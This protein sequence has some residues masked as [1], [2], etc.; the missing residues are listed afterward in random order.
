MIPVYVISLPN[1]ERREKIHAELARVGFK[2]VEY[3]SAK[4]PVAD[5]TANNFRRNPR[6]EYGCALSHIKA[7]TAAISDGCKEALFIEDDV[8]FADN[9]WQQLGNALDLLERDYDV[10]YLG[11]HP[12]GPVEKL[13]WINLY[14][15]TGG[16]SCAEAYCMTEYAMSGF[17][18]YWCDRAGQKNAMIDFIL[19]EYA[20]QGIGYAFYPTI[21]EQPPGYSQI[22]KKHDDKLDLIRRGWENNLSIR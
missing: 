8:V 2:D 1:K 5:F 16:F 11:G 15:L 17:V 10:L 18:Q 12:R 19:G 4:E 6:N 7:I 21:T 22:G 14:K 20:T 13:K 3:V 9:A